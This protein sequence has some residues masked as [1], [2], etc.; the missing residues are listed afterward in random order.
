VRARSYT[1]ADPPRAGIELAD[2]REQAVFG[3]AEVRA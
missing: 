3:G 1:Q 2:G